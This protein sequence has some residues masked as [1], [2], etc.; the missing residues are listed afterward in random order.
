MT[1][2]VWSFTLVL[3]VGTLLA[4]VAAA[5]TRRLRRFGRCPVNDHGVVVEVEA[6][7]WTG[8]A[9]DVVSCSEFMPPTDVRCDKRCLRGALR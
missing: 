5:R 6:S 8:A 4:I 9:T 1:P 2:A 3:G 7:P